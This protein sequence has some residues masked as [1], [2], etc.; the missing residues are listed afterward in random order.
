MKIFISMAI[1]Y[2]GFAITFH[3]NGFLTTHLDLHGLGDFH[4]AL[5]VA[6]IIAAFCVFGGQAAVVGGG[7][8]W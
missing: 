8:L 7:A 1:F 4:V 3:L 2:I 6:T 5:T